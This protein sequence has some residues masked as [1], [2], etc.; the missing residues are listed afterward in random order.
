MDVL[1]R[2][3]FGGFKCIGNG[4]CFSRHEYNCAGRS[5]DD[6]VGCGEDSG[7]TR[8]D[9]GRTEEV[10]GRTGKDAGSIGEDAGTTGEDAGRIRE[11]AARIGEDAGRI[12]EDAGRTSSGGHGFA[13]R[14]Q[15]G[16]SIHRISK[17]RSAR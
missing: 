6:R 16:P 3:C 2:S 9:A 8:E 15:S 13:G 1:S 12:G 10:A 7:R 11:N 5:G 14:L 4:R 17:R